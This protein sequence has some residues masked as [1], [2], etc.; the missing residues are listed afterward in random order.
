[1]AV[2]SRL[3]SFLCCLSSLKTQSCIIH[4]SFFFFPF[5]TFSLLLLLPSCAIQ[6]LI[7]ACGRGV[8]LA[9]GGPSARRD[10]GKAVIIRAL[11]TQ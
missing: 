10:E 1:M 9:R 6:Q 11:L 7:A 3:A 8:W 5:S 4:A 2:P